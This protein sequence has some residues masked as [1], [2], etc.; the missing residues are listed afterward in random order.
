MQTLLATILL[1]SAFTA[2]TAGRACFGCKRDTCM[3]V[4]AETLQ[5]QSGD[6]VVHGN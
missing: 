6:D 4:L 5:C 3:S 1:L 2:S